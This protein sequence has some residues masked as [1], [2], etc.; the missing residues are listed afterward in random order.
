MNENQRNRT[1]V[2]KALFPAGD[3]VQTL[4]TADQED[5]TPG[6]VFVVARH[7]DLHALR[8]RSSLYCELLVDETAAAL[9]LVGC[10]GLLRAYTE[11][12]PDLLRTV[13]ELLDEEHPEVLLGIVDLAA[14]DFVEPVRRRVV[15]RRHDDEQ[16]R[17]A[18]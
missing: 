14:G 2:A 18:A 9:N 12:R 16:A 10:D 7:G 8:M 17:A 15:I 6:L 11:L 1:M 5:G 4:V 13:E 3:V